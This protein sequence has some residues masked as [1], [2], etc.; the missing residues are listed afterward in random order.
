MGA[1]K[2]IHT[3]PLYSSDLFPDS[4]PC[5]ELSPDHTRL[6]LFKLAGNHSDSG[7]LEDLY[8]ENRDAIDF[9]VKRLFGRNLY[10]PALPVVL[11]AM[12]R[13]ARFFCNELEEPAEWVARC[14]V[15]ESRRAFAERKH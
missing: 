8:R 1:S 12:G 15:L 14:V 5:L 2:V 7:A 11:A 3:E 13:Q 9:A 4:I 10:L 6:A